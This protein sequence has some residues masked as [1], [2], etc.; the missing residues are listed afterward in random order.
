MKTRTTF[1]IG[2]IASL[3]TIYSLANNQED[4]DIN[5]VSMYFVV[6]LIPVLLILICNSIYLFY[7]ARLKNR[8]TKA[9][10]SLAPVVILVILSMQSNLV[11]SSIDGNLVFATTTCAISL[12]ISNLVWSANTFYPDEVKS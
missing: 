8:R 10:L 2:L 7:I 4:G 12:A 5:A 9:L 1:L 3:I 11:V 6:F